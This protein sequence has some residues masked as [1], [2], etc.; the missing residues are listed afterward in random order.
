MG[1]GG[2]CVDFWG[3]KCQCIL[4]IFEDYMIGIWCVVWMIF[5]GEI[6][7]KDFFVWVDFMQM[8]IGVVVVKFQ[9]EDWF[10][11]LIDFVYEE[12]QQDFLGSYVVDKIV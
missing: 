11:N 6:K 3:V 2:Y 10:V 9:F 8:V 4:D 1:K 7:Y 5:Y 12:F